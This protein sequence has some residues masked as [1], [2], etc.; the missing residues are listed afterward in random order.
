MEATC[1]DTF[2]QY[3]KTPNASPVPAN[4]SCALN[5]MKSS[6]FTARKNGVL[7]LQ[8][9]PGRV[10]SGGCDG[11][12]FRV[13][14]GHKHS[15][16]LSFSPLCMLSLLLSALCLLRVRATHTQH[17]MQ[18]RTREREREREKKQRMMICQWMCTTCTENIITSQSGGY[19]E[20]E[21]K[22]IRVS[23]YVNAHKLVTHIYCYSI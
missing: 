5:G 15:Q 7:V 2:A 1:R 19:E 13:M 8:A 11:C 21:L 20:R 23:T 12:C 9:T 10:G 16:F 18:L 17:T 22:E 14:V 3:T 4:A 6:K